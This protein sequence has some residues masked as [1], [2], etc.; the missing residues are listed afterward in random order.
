MLSKKDSEQPT[1][2]DKTSL[3]FSLKDKP[4]ALF[5]FLKPFA[6]RN[7][8]LTKIESR[9][10]KVKPWEYVFFMEIEEHRKN[11]RCKEALKYAKKLCEHLKVLGSYPKET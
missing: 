8:N 10:S 4:G 7:I 1:G 9:P 3:T 2:K 5:R 11:K 6:D